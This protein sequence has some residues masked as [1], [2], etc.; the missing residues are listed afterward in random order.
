M[1]TLPDALTHRVNHAWTGNLL[2]QSIDIYQ[3]DCRF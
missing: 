1:D 3:V 2:I